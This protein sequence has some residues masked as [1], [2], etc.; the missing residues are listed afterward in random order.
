MDRRGRKKDGIQWMEGEER[1]REY[2][3]KEGK[4]EEGLQWMGGGE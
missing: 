1:K 4:K 3:R 2:N